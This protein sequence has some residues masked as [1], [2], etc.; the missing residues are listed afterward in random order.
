MEDTGQVESALDDGVEGHFSGR[1][2]VGLDGRD[3]GI[4]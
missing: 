4:A 2:V 3:D 1:Q